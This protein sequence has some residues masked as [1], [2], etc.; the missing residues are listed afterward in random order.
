MYLCITNKHNRCNKMRIVIA[1]GGNALLQRGEPLE[2]AIQLKNVISAC[3]TLA[4]VALHNQII[5]THGNGPQVGLLA[6]QNDAYKAVAP[7]P[8]YV[9]GAQ[10]EGMIGS[11]FVQE[12]RNNIQHKNVACL[13]THTVVDHNDPGFKD[14]T[15]FVG[16]T[17]STFD[18]AQKLAQI[19]GW[20]VKPDGSYYRRVVPSPKPC[21]IV[22][23]DVINYLLRDEKTIMVCAGGGGIPVIE[24]DGTICGI[25]AVIDKDRASSLLAVSIKADALIILSDVEAVE[26]KFGDPQSRKIKA[27][28]TKA[29][30]EFNFAAGS[31]GPKVDSA[32]SFV[33]NGGKFAAIGEL[34]KIEGILEGVV[35]TRVTNEC[36]VV[37]YY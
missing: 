26:T 2:A 31:M 7:Y 30:R 18:E 25:D 4:K 37:Q 24:K 5:L 36:G 20:T 19:H 10:T 3:T 22:E 8:L 14:P 16:P 15:K 12:L 6:L 1:L 9:L 23:I 34:T 27:I 17:Y 28:N 11:L 29:L 21:K 13:L 35:G 33:E 32:I